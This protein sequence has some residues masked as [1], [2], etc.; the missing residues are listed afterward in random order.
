M[1]AIIRGETFFAMSS[2]KHYLLILA[3]SLLPFL[4]ILGNPN[5]PHTSDG[6]V[7]LPRIAAYVRALADGHFPT[8]WAGELNY[9]YGLP[10]FNFMYH[11]P[12]LIASIF[13]AFGVSLVYSFKIVLVLSFL[14]SGIFMYSF[15]KELLKDDQK[16]F[17]IA[18]FYQFAPFRLVELLV[19]GSI[20]SAYTY[21]FLPLILL[22][23]VRRSFFLTSIAVGLLII[24]HNSLSL[25]FFGLALAYGLI[26]LTSRKTFLTALLAGLGLSAFYWIPALVERSYTYGDLFMKD[27]FRS[28]F[29]PFINFFV[30]NFTNDVSLRTAEISVQLG[31][32]HTAALLVAIILIWKKSVREILTKK[33]F[34]T[35]IALTLF[36]LYFMQ[37]LSLNLWEKV[38]LLRQFQF[39]W[40]FLA[41]ITFTS[42]MLAPSLLMLPLFKKRLSFIL[43]CVFVIFSTA[44]YWYPPQGFDTVR[45]EDFWNYPL[46][47]TYFGETD[48]IWS[49]GPAKEY[50]KNRIQIIEGVATI[51][52]FIKKTQVHVF[53]VNAETPVRLVD[54]T[55]YFPGWRVYVDEQKVPIEFQ[56]AN[57]RGLITFAVPA[58]NHSVRVVFGESKTR[59]VADF[60][61]LTTASGLG[62]LFLWSKRKKL[63]S[64]RL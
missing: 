62:M 34:V 29:P 7:H 61:S 27:L 39:P 49:A 40:R 63:V 55:Q 64:Q 33:I 23:I 47:T 19:R 46:N 5:L 53:S 58:G 2:F 25:V 13:I 36:T 4:I 22:G 37:P 43:L 24:S 32:F 38:S 11:T 48:L 50:P 52:D 21:T 8:R 14:L 30:P 17:L 28:H 10:L 41:I 18:L 42:A 9:G 35:S 45:D 12:Y 26:I 59:I 3:I 54:H 6:G 60:I 1:S 20:G 15:A 31:L 56:D 51:S 57:W 16:A 44:Y